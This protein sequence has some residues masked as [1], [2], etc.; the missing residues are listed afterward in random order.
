MKS[1]E[2][3]DVKMKTEKK[4]QIIKNKKNRHFFKSQSE[5]LLI[6]IYII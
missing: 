2:Q 5:K 6:I 3:F 1:N 4:L